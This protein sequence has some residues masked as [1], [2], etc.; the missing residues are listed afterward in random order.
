MTENGVSAT[1][2]MYHNAKEQHAALDNRLQMLLKKPYLTV[3]EEIEIMVL[4]K[5]K[6]YF[7]DLMEKAAEETREARDNLKKNGA[8]IFVEALKAEGIDTLFCYPGGATLNITD[9]L[10]HSDIQAGGGE[11]RAG[12][13]ARGGRLRPGVRQG[14]G[15]ACHIGPRRDE[16]GDGHCHGIYGLHTPR[17]FFL[18]GA[19]HADRE[20]C[21]PGSGY[22]G[23]H[24]A[25][26]QAQLPRER[27]ERLTRI[28]KEAFYIAAS[29]RPGPVLV[30]IP[31][32][33]SAAIGG[34]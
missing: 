23:D 32:D 3:D 6:L 30:D 31:K 8:Q 26:H 5:K 19:H 24:E 27:R 20:R 2:E 13:G 11:A 33:V 34:V 14:R 9:A 22:R 29:G 17:D 18:P 16:H 28:M 15:I 7:K 4:K 10:Y 12:R 1:E 25:V 21:I